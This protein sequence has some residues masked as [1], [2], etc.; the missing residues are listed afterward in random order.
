MLTDPN[1]DS[2]ANIDAAVRTHALLLH[3]RPHLIPHDCSR[4]SIYNYL[5]TSVHFFPF[6]R[7]CSARIPKNSGRWY[8]S[9]SRDRRKWHRKTRKRAQQRVCPLPFHLDGV[10]QH[11]YKCDSIGMQPRI[12]FLPVFVHAAGNIA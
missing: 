3:G 11:S 2:P 12:K 10:L 6:N 9:V 7:K 5:M 4:D 8:P 1:I